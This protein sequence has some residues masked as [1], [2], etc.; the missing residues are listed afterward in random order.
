MKR[1][2]STWKL[3][4][5][6]VTRQEEGLSVVENALLL[7]LVALICVGVITAFGTRINAMCGNLANS[8]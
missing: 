7:A 2:S 1:L 8:L 4:V 3:I 5:K 6:F